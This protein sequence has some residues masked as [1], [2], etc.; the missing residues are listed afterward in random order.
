MKGQGIGL[1]KHQRAFL[2]LIATLTAD[3]LQLK[4]H[5]LTWLFSM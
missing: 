5:L 4:V 3:T 1:K 2:M